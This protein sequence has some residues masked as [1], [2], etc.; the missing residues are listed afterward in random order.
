MPPT[1]VPFEIIGP[2]GELERVMTPA[3]FQRV[4]EFL[5]QK[6]QLSEEDLA[7]A[8]ALSSRPDLFALYEWMAHEGSNAPIM[9]GASS[10]ALAQAKMLMQMKNYKA[11]LVRHGS[12]FREPTSQLFMLLKGANV[13][14]VMDR[15]WPENSMVAFKRDV[16]R[17]FAA[18]GAP[19]EASGDFEDPFNIGR[20]IL[21]DCCDVNGHQKPGN[22]LCQIAQ[23]G[24]FDSE[25][26]ALRTEIKTG[27]LVMPGEITARIFYCYDR[28]RAREKRLTAY[29]F[30]DVYLGIST[31]LKPYR[32]AEEFFTQKFLH[33]M[34]ETDPSGY[35]LFAFCFGNSADTVRAGIDV[36]VCKAIAES[37]VLKKWLLHSTLTGGPHNAAAA[38]MLNELHSSS[39]S[40]WNN[41]IMR[42]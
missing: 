35:S 25:L 2:D 41:A 12:I 34:A 27:K 20:E 22:F 10:C 14:P 42:I 18:R 13:L 3:D 9:F 21:T 23:G 15:V 37:E 7:R 39:R 1:D 31:M 17:I 6:P 8:R 38:S 26:E 24:V 4:G 16:K 19:A 5:A 40:L 36:S 32:T 11:I 29:L 28:L 33:E 30:I